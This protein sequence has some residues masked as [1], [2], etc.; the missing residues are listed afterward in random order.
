ML[1]NTEKVRNVV[2]CTLC[3]CYPMG[4]L[5]QPPQWYTSDTYR[6]RVI[7]EPGA[8]LEEMGTH[9]GDDVEIRV[10]DSS[11]DTRYMVI[12]A[13]PR[14]TERLSEQALADLVT[15]D[16][17]IGVGDALPPWK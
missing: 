9:V 6:D 2:V 4:L 10:Y 12:P 15:R 13:R 3:S 11:A 14:G 1:E 17:L 7:R 8:V 5:G 16:S